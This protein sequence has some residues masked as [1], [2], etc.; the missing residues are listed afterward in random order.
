MLQPSVSPHGQWCI[1][2]TELSIE[3]MRILKRIVT[4]QWVNSRD[5]QEKQGAHPF[6]QGYDEHNPWILIEFWTNDGAA[7]GNFLAYCNEQLG[8]T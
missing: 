5:Y 8:I 4:N 6:L 7:I 1:Q 3:H 2:S